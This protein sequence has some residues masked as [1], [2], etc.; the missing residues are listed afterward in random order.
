MKSMVRLL[1]IFFP[2]SS[3]FIKIFQFFFFLALLT[4]REG[5][6]IDTFRYGDSSETVSSFFPGRAVG[7]PGKYRYIPD[8]LLE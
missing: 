6:S 7:K 3:F 1:P 4:I 2:I 5:G 8:L